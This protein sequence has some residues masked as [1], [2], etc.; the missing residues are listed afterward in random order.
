MAK[1]MGVAGYL[2]RHKHRVLDRILRVDHAGELGADR[3]Y[4]GQSFVINND[5]KY[6]PM[7]QDMWNQEKVHLEELEYMNLKYRTR[8]SLM[9]PFW[10]IGGFLLGSG[11]ALLGPKAAM[12]C[13]VA[14]ERV[15]TQHYNDQIR[16]LLSEGD[17]K[18]SGY[19]LDKFTKFRDDEEHHHDTAE[20]EG[21]DEHPNL[22]RVVD[23]VCKASIKIAEKI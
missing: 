19:I 8:K 11:T 5:P 16:E 17:A 22:T 9:E 14:V 13:T 3:I 15:I 20:Q 10:S 7:I 1:S 23:T 21:T 2:N 4:H 18:D 6:T 12:A